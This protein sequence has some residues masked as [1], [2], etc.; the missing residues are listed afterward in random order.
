MANDL[1]VIEDGTILSMLADAKYTSA[2]PCLYNKLEIFRNDNLP[3]GECRRKRHAR[4]RTEMAKIKSCLAALSNEKKAELK[5][6]LGAAKLRVTYV[7]ASGQV[8]ALTF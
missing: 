8:V 7:N 4:Q 2:I 5:K 6:L 1:V 3:C